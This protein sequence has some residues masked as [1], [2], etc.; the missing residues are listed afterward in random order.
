[1][2]GPGEKG[3]EDEPE[4]AAA[5]RE[6]PVEIFPIEESYEAY[7]EYNSDYAASEPVLRLGRNNRRRIRRR[8]RDH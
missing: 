4:T 1:V 8:N 3:P 5:E 2:K 6:S 7:D